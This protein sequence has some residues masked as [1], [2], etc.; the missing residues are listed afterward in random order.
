MQIKV[1]LR[2]CRHRGSFGWRWGY[3]KIGEYSTYTRRTVL[4]Y[5]RD[6]GYRQ[7]LAANQF[8]LRAFEPELFPL[9]R[10]AG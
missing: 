5:W 9:R 3:T 7:L 4:P 8:D 2:D 6:L 10:T 1:L